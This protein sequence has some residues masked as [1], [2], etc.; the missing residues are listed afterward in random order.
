MAIFRLL[1]LTTVAL[2]LAACQPDD[3]AAQAPTPST[4]Q[5]APAQPTVAKPG[6]AAVETTHWQCGDLGI[7]TRFNDEALDAITL[8]FSGRR[9]V[10]REATAAS[11]AR[12]ADEAGNE[13]WSRGGDVTLTLAG[14]DKTSC[15][16]TKQPS[17]WN[18][19]EARGVAYR[20]VGN[21]P[22]WFA[23]V[24]SGAESTLRATLDY[25]ERKLEVARTQELAGDDVGF[26]GKTADGTA[27]VL[28]IE[29]K[30]CADGMSGEEFEATAQ[31]EVADKTYRGCAAF[32]GD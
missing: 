16:K 11:G 22:G 27:V 2:L 24:S 32:L 8:T 31:L 28:R 29:A 13:F 10:L 18:E 4:G 26:E 9:L 14:K 5:P 15:T 25:G 17:P 3:R 1:P 19:A 7:A 30:P 6:V 20:A 12:F 21:E 23:E